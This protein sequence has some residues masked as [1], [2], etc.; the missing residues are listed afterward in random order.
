MLQACAN[1]G[2]KTPTTAT[3][4]K[5]SEMGDQ[6]LSAIA[7]GVCLSMCVLCVCVIVCFTVPGAITA[8]NGVP[9][10]VNNHGL[11]T[12]FLPAQLVSHVI[13]S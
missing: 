4:Y 5:L 11:H 13:C 7:N 6:M 10:N 3:V 2:N 8:M 9:D 1:D 12:L